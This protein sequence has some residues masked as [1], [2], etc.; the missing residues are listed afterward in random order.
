MCLNVMK[1]E[2]FV[3]YI[4]GA[5]KFIILLEIVFALF[6]RQWVTA[7]LSIIIL[8]VVLSPVYL[9]SQLEFTIPKEFQI[10]IILFIF[11]SLF[12][13]EIHDYY[14]RFWWW[15]ILLHASSGFLLGILGFLLVYVL[16]E[17]REVSVHM[18]AHF[19][20]I[21]AFFFAVGMG[22]LWE[23]FEFAMDSLFGFNMQKPMLDDPSGLTD[24]MW[25]LIVDTLGAFCIS[26]FGYLYLWSGKRDFFIEKMINSFIEKNPR[27]FEK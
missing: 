10:L 27:F 8:L 9:Q 22:A 21:F 20:A 26:V 3:T 7:I 16:N 19:V 13:G 1:K 4:D 17:S 14:A 2:Q 18:T 23:I 24:T 25:D 11:A 12:L 6:E 5:I 15:D